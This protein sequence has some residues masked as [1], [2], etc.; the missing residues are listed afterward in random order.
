MP[1][2]LK[3]RFRIP[4]VALA[5]LSA[6]ALVWALAGR[7]GGSRAEAGPPAG[8]PQAP[9]ARAAVPATRVS[10][11]SAQS[12]FALDQT[13]PQV[14][15]VQATRGGQNVGIQSHTNFRW[16]L[17]LTRGDWA[18]RESGVVLP[19]APDFLP[20]GP[21]AT[22]GWFTADGNGNIRGFETICVGGQV[23]SDQRFT[24]VATL[25][26]RNGFGNSVITFEGGKTVNVDWV[27]FDG[28][29]QMHYVWN[30]AGTAITG[31]A[32]KQRAR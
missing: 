32:W 4:A 8:G 12:M 25:N 2:F 26:E 3:R 27:L 10:L 5:A 1:A 13:T 23:L 28:G 20:E 14:Q 17:R 18:Y 24:G 19:G 11:A 7:T 22:V 21:F 30:L 29:R 9:P 15:L 31:S 16:T 6:A